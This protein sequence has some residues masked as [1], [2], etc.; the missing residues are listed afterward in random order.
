MIV[1][2]TVA[3]FICVAI[4]FASISAYGEAVTQTSKMPFY[5]N[6]KIIDELVS[7]E[8]DVLLEYK[9]DVLADPMGIEYNMTMNRMNCGICENEQFV[10]CQSGNAI[11]ISERKD[12]ENAIIKQYITP[13]ADVEGAFARFFGRELAV[14]MPLT[15]NS[16]TLYYIDP[17]ALTARSLPECNVI[18]SDDGRYMIAVTR[19]GAIYVFDC[20]NEKIFRVPEG[21][22]Y[23]LDITYFRRL[24]SNG[25]VIYRNDKPYGY[26][27]LENMTVYGVD[28]EPEVIYTGN[29]YYL[30]REDYAIRRY[31]K[32]GSDIFFKL[33]DDQYFAEKNYDGNREPV[34]SV[35]NI[36]LCGDVYY[37]RYVLPP[38]REGK[39]ENF[40]G[41]RMG[42]PSLLAPYSEVSLDG[43]YALRLRDNYRI[44]DHDLKYSLTQSNYYYSFNEKGYLVTEAN[45]WGKMSSNYNDLMNIGV[46]VINL[47]ENDVYDIHLKIEVN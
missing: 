13:F 30:V 11:V 23:E 34:Y 45:G 22:G 39:T 41:S 44:K 16:G 3:C 9:V 5:V 43:F 15:T 21:A 32:G 19:A 33:V 12:K 2:K 35:G 4:A 38:N 40:V 28:L 17:I 14:F 29:D 26:L 6:D 46:H 7:T 37:S 18:S 27:C 36:I 20:E 31:F 24:T 8:P 1:K 47:E 25:G 42:L 10:I